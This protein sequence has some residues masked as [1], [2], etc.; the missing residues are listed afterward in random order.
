MTPSDITPAL[1][2]VAN[3]ATQLYV[4]INTRLSPAGA[5]CVHCCDTGLGFLSEDSE[6]LN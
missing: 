2:H 4:D 6:L 3:I 1:A 5:L